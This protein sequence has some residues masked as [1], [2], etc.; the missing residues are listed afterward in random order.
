MDKE[1]YLIFQNL[2]SFCLH[3]SILLP[4]LNPFQKS[5]SALLES[6]TVVWISVKLRQS[7][8]SYW[9]SIIQIE[10]RIK[11]LKSILLRYP[12]VNL[13]SWHHC[14]LREPYT[15]AKRTWSSPIMLFSHSFRRTFN[16]TKNWGFILVHFS[17]TTWIPHRI[18]QYPFDAPLL[19][20]ARRW[21]YR[22][23]FNLPRA[24]LEYLEDLALPLAEM[25]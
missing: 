2:S 20:R 11:L 1:K 17:I 4:F 22:I 14:R 7:Y 16:I 18:A 8:L 12:P 21:R 10:V 23:L 19:W 9:Y 13:S 24:D 15:L 6:I 3:D 25:L 5:T